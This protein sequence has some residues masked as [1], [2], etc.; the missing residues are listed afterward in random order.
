MNDSA[1]LKVTGLSKNFGGVKAVS[2]IDLEM[3]E[4][5]ML[6]FIGPNGSGKTTI[7][8]LITGFV[9]PS[10]GKIYFRDKNITA[11]APHKRVRLGIVGRQ[12]GN[13]FIA[14]ID[15]SGRRPHKPGD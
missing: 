6:G 10:A 14:K 3:K 1:I 4:G 9:R 7:A 2:N 12:S 11:L 15:F 8:N 13:I 5:E